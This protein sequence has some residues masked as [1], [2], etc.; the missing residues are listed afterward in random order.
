MRCGLG[1]AGWLKCVAPSLGP[2]QGRYRTALKTFELSSSDSA[3][4]QSGIQIALAY[5]DP[6]DSFLSIASA[7][8]AM[9]GDFAW[10]TCTANA[11]IVI[12]LFNRMI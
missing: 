8:A 10:A 3:G 12:H 4:Q 2:G 11:Q 5:A 6:V 1:R 7:A 9:D